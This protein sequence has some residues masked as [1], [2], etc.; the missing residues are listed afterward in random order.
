MAIVQTCPKCEKL[1]QGEFRMQLMHGPK[2]YRRYAVHVEC[3]KGKKIQKAEGSK[4]MEDETV[5]TTCSLGGDM[6]G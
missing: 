2:G 3:P 1:I 5:S 4:Q 6:R